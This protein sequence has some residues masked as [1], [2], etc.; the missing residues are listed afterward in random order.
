MNGMK[1]SNAGKVKE[2]IQADEGYLYGFY[3]A[4]KETPLPKRSLR[5][6][7]KSKPEGSTQ[8]KEMTRSEKKRLA[9]KWFD[10]PQGETG[11]DL[12]RRIGTTKM[13][14]NRWQKE[15]REEAKVEADPNYDPEGE[16]FKNYQKVDK[17]LMKA[18]ERG[19]PGALKIFY[20]LTNRLVEKTENTNL[21]LTADDITRRQLEAERRLR[22]LGYR[23]E[24]VPDE[25]TLLPEDV[26][27]STGQGVKGND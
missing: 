8:E 13:S 10:D 9:K 1:V 7:K 16:L 18:C 12:C 6:R 14:L 23:V 17:A 24:D 27:S 22:E 26:R 25:P 21:D 19:S 11:A 5:V 20:Q 15:W 2:T 4:K 3:K